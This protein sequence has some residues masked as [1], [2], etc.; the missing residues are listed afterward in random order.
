MT[1]KERDALQC[2]SLSFLGGMIG[3]GGEDW[4]EAGFIAKKPAK[5]SMGGVQYNKAGNQL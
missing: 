3:R 4:I 2:V 1:L 5:D